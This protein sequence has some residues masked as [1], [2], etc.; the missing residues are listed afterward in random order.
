MGAMGLTAGERRVIIEVMFGSR[1]R[2]PGRQQGLNAR[3]GPPAPTAWDLLES[4]P[5]DRVDKVLSLSELAE[6]VR[7]DRARR[8]R[9]RSDPRSGKRGPSSASTLLSPR[10]R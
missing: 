1:K 8:T 6:A 5:R 7:T 10:R 3:S 2:G 9:R 4:D